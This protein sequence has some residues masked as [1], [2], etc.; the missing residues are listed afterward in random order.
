M[1][2]K[3]KI[4][5]KTKKSTGKT[6]TIVFLIILLFLSLGYIGY[7]EYIK[8]QNKTKKVKKEV[9]EEMYYSE[10]NTML[11]QIELYNEVLKSE[12]PISNL[13]NIDNQLKLQ[14]GILALKKNENIS[15][16]YKIEDIKEIYHN[17]FKQGFKAIY[18][19]IDCPYQD[20]ILYKLN[21]ET[22]TFV[23][24]HAH[25]STSI[26]IDTYFVSGKID[27]NKYILNT[28]ILYSNYCNDTCS[29]E[30]SSYYSS[31][32]DCVEEK[33]PI[34]DTRSQYN[35]IKEE[36]PV[37]TFTFIKDKNLFRLESISLKS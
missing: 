12:Y 27:G 26:D 14:F 29:P 16:Y 35:K 11:S 36:L 34:M 2:E 4:I 5:Y 9:R 37:T 13:N 22:Y 10:V 20:D 19:D 1:E 32:Q 28:H 3:S 33:A 17:Y 23:D 8:Y 18:E 31:Y 15:N 21:N 25:G 30:Q 24:H 6:I 7:S